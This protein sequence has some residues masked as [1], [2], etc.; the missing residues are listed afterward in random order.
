[1]LVSR[2]V[3]STHRGIAADYFAR[4]DRG[5]GPAAQMVRFAEPLLEAA[6]DDSA[7]RQMALNFGM[8]C[9]NLALCDEARR[10]EMLGDLVSRMATDEHDAERLRGLAATMVMRHRRL[11]PEMHTGTLFAGDA[12]DAAADG[13]G[14]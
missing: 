3:S 9:W 8:A 11:Y 12:C 1:M 7:R 2:G 14:P 6:G 4:K 10:E 13:V 5:E